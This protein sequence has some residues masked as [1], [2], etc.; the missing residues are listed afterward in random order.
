MDAVYKMKRFKNLE[1]FENHTLL[2]ASHTRLEILNSL[3]VGAI[4]LL[5]REGPASLRAGTSPSHMPRT[6]TRDPGPGLPAL[7][8]G[9]LVC[10]VLAVCSGQTTCE[11]GCPSLAAG[12]TEEQRSHSGQRPQRK[13]RR[14]YP[15]VPPHPTPALTLSCSE[16]YQNCKWLRWPS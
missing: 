14:D 1:C 2:E 16:P 5:R 3:T 4:C 7:N 8:T 6:Q 9:V 13:W 11:L 15:P 12:K 10:R